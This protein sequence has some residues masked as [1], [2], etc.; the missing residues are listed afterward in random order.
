MKPEAKEIIA[1]AVAK[2]KEHGAEAIAERE[3]SIVEA[4]A[5]AGIETTENT[6]KKGIRAGEVM[7]TAGPGLGGRNPPPH[8]TDEVGPEAGA[9]TAVQSGDAAIEEFAQEA[10]GIAA[11]SVPM[12]RGSEDCMLKVE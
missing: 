3:E 11:E 4:T 9:V 5:E 2:T 8:E 7:T 12:I 10:E 1:E 6:A